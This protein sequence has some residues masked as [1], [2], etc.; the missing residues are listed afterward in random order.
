M[1]RAAS[2]TAVP[3][4][5]ARKLST[6]KLAAFGA[7]AWGYL[8]GLPAVVRHCAE[9]PLLIMSMP[10]SG[11][12]WIGAVLGASRSA[13]YMREPI[14]FAHRRSGGS[15]AVFE[16]TGAPQHAAV[17]TAAAYAFRGIPRFPHSV[18]QYPHQ[19]RLSGHASRRTVIKEVNPTA[20][21]YFREH[22][23]FH[24]ILVLRHPLA[25]ARSFWDAGWWPE[26]DL[27]WAA[28]RLA[29]V[30]QIALG[31]VGDIRHDIVRYETLCAAPGEEFA[32]LAARHGLAF[33]GPAAEALAASMAPGDRRDRYSIKREPAVMANLWKEQF[34]QSQA[35]EMYETYIAAGLGAYSAY[36]EWIV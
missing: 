27:A 33:E 3:A 12:S 30:W 23:D 4:R 22:Y 20:L 13:A 17:R 6:A 21:P 24:L 18:L 25:I 1:S 5:R 29:I 35:D 16:V 15:G 11:S 32:R 36:R 28:R 8:P 2:G 19:W 10:R 14:S 31:S 34:T 26:G 9:P 7:T